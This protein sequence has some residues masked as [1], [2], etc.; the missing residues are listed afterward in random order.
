M[1]KRH[2]ADLPSRQI[3]YREREGGEGVP[4]LL[5]HASPGSAKQLEGL[6]GHFRPGRRVIAFDRPGNG[7]S[8]ALD[9]AQPEIADYA[10]VA[11]EFLDAL[12]VPQAD[13][14]G[15]HTGA[16]I[17]AE[18]AV[19][20]PDRVRCVIQDGIPVYTPERTA[21]LLEHYAPAFPPDLDGAYLIRAF[22]FLRDQYLFSP[23]FERSKAARRMNGLPA[24]EILHDW[25]LELLKA[26][27]TYP[28]GYHAAFRYRAIDRLPLVSQPT[29]ALAPEDDGLKG[30]T[31]ELAE[32]CAN[33]R[34][35]ELPRYDADN[36][37]SATAGAVDDFLGD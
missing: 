2:F 33:F 37:L 28:L 36:Y 10:S 30:V 13:V 29:L 24:P 31:R 21:Y 34:F 11:V 18:M 7:D 20:A 22:N 5:F 32:K 19:I 23:W 8:P 14:Y 27:T 15:T 4:L 26:P 1:I 9:I 25:L 6:M 12:R 3:H 35:V 16:S 17:A